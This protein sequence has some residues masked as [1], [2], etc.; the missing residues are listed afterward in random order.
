M[1]DEQYDELAYEKEYCIV[2][3]FQHV[4]L[5]R[6]T[7][8]KINWVVEPKTEMIKVTL[9]LTESFPGFELGF[10]YSFNLLMFQYT[11]LD[12]NLSTYR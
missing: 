2:L 10:A 3:I 6:F 4:Y 5:Y 12:N 9:D 8:N 1:T 7:V 11:D